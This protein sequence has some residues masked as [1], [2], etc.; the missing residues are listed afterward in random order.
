M[1][2]FKGP[3]FRETG[4]LDI[5]PKQKETGRFLN[6]ESSHPT[7]GIHISWPLAFCRRLWTRSA[8][9]CDYFAARDIFFRRLAASQF[10]KDVIGWI[11]SH[12]IFIRPYIPSARTGAKSKAQDPGHVGFS[13]VWQPMVYHKL[14]FWLPRL[15][16][17]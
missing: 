4:R 13:G 8:S 1:V 11:A 10:P 7:P 2:V 5:R 9:L 14:L 15:H 17:P 6:L 12:T 3:R 16:L